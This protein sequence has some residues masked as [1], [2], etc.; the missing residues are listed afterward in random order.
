MAFPLR[1]PM[2]EIECDYARSSGPGGQNV[3]KVNSK[4]ILRWNV[5]MTPSLPEPVRARFFER[6]G[7]RLTQDGDLV[8]MSDRFRDQK[9]NFEDCVAKVQAMLDAVARPPK[10]RVKTKPTK[11]S[12]RRRLSDKRAH[13]EKKASRRGSSGE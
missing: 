1:V 10:P 8:V 6:F 2:A 7:T 12:Q 13:S 9:R 11:G 5:A 3:N 4:C